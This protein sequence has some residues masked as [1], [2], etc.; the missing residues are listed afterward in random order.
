MVSVVGLL[1]LAS[2]VDRLLMLHARRCTGT[3][4]SYSSREISVAA[5]S[6]L[7]TEHRSRIEYTDHRGRTC[8]F[9]H[10]KELAPGEQV[11]VGH[12]RHRPQMPR[13]IQRPQD[14]DGSVRP[15]AER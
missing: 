2:A 14:A 13:V 5:I 9:T 10:N 8:S 1:L 6:A 3:V 4:V 11:I 12:R 15:P 7:A